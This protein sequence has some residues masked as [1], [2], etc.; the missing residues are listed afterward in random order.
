[1][2]SLADFPFPSDAGVTI[3]V[4]NAKAKTTMVMN[5]K[6]FNHLTHDV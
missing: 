5:P 6:E 1:V 2:Y 4:R 3:V